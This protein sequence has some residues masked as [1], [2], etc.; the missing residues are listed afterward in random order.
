MELRHLKTFQAVAGASSFTRAAAELGYVQSAVTTHVKALEE[1]LG[2]KLF[3]RLGR[4]IALTAAGRELRPYARRMVELSEE[5]RAAVCC[6]G[7]E[8]DGVVAVSASETLCAHRMPPMVKELGRRHPEIKVRFLP[9]ATG[10]LDADLVRA[11]SEGEIDAAFVMEEELGLPGRRSRAPRLPEYLA[12]EL[13]SREPLVMVA[14]PEHPLSRAQSVLPDELEGAPVL[15]TE[16][17]CG[18]RRVFERALSEFGV[19]PEAAG[20]FTSAEAVK[21]CAEAGMGMA[22][23]AEVS[24][25]AEL[26]AGALST[27]S[28]RGPELNVATYMAWHR[29]RWISPVLGALMEVARETLRHLPKSPQDKLPGGN[30]IRR[31]LETSAPAQ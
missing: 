22:V 26:E 14:S 24:V 10:A 12:T 15:F 27:L 8:L 1:E 28:W 29:E 23:L 31:K 18:Y 7:G 9:S 3:D 6:G 13:L 19:S 11:I 4:R 17:G 20:E 30:A 21:R 5:A 16:R 25:A 2:V